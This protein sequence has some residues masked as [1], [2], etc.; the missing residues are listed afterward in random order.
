[1]YISS[2]LTNKR[3]NKFTTYSL[4]LSLFSFSRI[5]LLLHTFMNATARV[6][7]KVRV[8]PSFDKP[9]LT[10]MQSAQDFAVQLRLHFKRAFNSIMEC[11]DKYY[12]KI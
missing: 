2:D 1:M 3:T 8:A 10:L 6:S 11:N 12:D 9:F 7:L 4:F 5:V